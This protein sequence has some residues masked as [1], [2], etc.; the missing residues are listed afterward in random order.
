M[1]SFTQSHAAPARAGRREWAALCVLLLPLLLVSMDVSVLYFAVPFIAQELG[2]TATEQ[3]WILDIYA[4]VLAGLLL[5]MGALGDRIG[6]RRLLLIG[7][8]AFGAASLAAAYADGPGELI[9]ARAL[10]GLGGATLMPATLALIRNLFRDPRQRATAIAIWSAV[11]SS[12]VALGPVIS[13]VLLEHYWWG[14]VFLIN[15]PAMLTLLALAPFLVPESR[16]ERAGRF[17]RLSSLLS[18]AAILPAVYAVKETAAHGFQ[19][20]DGLALALAAVF[21]VLFVRRQSRCPHPMLP[22]DLFR[23]RGVPAALASQLVAMFVMVGSAVFTTQ[24]L[25]MV[26]GYSPLTAALWSLLPPLGVAVA[27]P[28]AVTLA[29]T[30]NRAYLIAAGFCLAVAGLLLIV[31]VEVDSPL[32]HV[33]VGIGV[34][35]AGLAAVMTLMTDLVVGAAPPERAGSASATVE[36]ASEL[37]GALGMA[38]LGSIGAAVYRGEIRDTLA[39]G[40]AA[41]TLGGAVQMA[42]QLPDEAGRTLLAAARTAFTN[43]MNVAALVAAVLA[44]ATAG[45][46]AHRLRHTGTT[47]TGQPVDDTSAPSGDAAA[48]ARDTFAPATA[49]GSDRGA[50]APEPRVAG[51]GE[52]GGV[53]GSDRGLVRD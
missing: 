25:Q 33:L 43:G 36:C 52:P 24:Y 11:L 39:D 18:L 51:P 26:L 35:S 45:L 10:L 13:G 20:L 34:C 40:P 16:N 32:W 29:R 44:L 31:R 17:D 9:T 8:V 6:R 14:S 5:T 38:I 53:P 22:P 30:V 19:A 3:L 28:A 46:A 49:R 41:E 27:A 50:T 7:A 47:P 2:P 4:F 12:G 23:V 48:T 37:G 21:G 42:G 15:L 1:R